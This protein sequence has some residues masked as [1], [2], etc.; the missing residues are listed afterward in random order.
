MTNNILVKLIVTRVKLEGSTASEYVCSLWFSLSKFSTIQVDWESEERCFQTFA[1]ECSR[2]YAFK[3]DPFQNDG[4]LPKD[5][6]ETSSSSSRSWQWTVEHVL[7][8]AFR[9]GLV[10]PSRFSEDGTLLQIAN[11]PD[12]YKVFERC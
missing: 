3:P 4:N 12:L 10:P 5:D 11:L 9:T 6:S 1:Q 2:F 8:P 7:F